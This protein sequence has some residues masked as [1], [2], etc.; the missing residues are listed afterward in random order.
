MNKLKVQQ[1]VF[2][3]FNVSNEKISNCITFNVL[4]NVT[5][6]SIRGKLENFVFLF[7][8]YFFSGYCFGCTGKPTKSRIKTDNGILKKI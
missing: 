4:K 2:F 8:S 5:S 7:V 3:V 6:E 1:V